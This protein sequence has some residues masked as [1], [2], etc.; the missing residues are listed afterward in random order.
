[1][2]NTELTRLFQAFEQIFPGA[3]LK[4]IDNN[5]KILLET[6]FPPDCPQET[7]IYS[8]YKEL[9]TLKGKEGRLF[10][11]MS[12]PIYPIY[13][14][15][16]FTPPG[17]IN[18]ILTAAK[19]ADSV[20][21]LFLSKPTQMKQETRQSDVSLLLDHLLHPAS[22]EDHTYTALLATELG[23]D[24]SLPR[25]VCIFQ[26]E[27]EG[28]SSASRAQITYSILQTMGNFVSTSSRQDIL[29][30]FGS[31]E[32]I[33]CH[34]MEGDFDSG[35]FLETLYT[36]IN[37]NY[38]VKCSVGVG[39][40]VRSL[41]DYGASLSSARSSF[42]YAGGRGSSGQRIYYVTDFLVEHLVYQI[43]ET[44]FEHFF[45]KELSYLQCNETAFETL[46]AL[47]E[48]D[49]DILPASEALFIHRNT[50]IFRLN[51]LKKHLG[52]NPLHCD[53]DRF[54]LIL[55]YHY[56]VKKYY[57]SNHITEVL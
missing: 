43:P 21:H 7:A 5:G 3:G 29:G 22:T 37:K 26:M 20:I 33:L 4:I 54:K 30:S 34:V 6:P 56:Y 8:N 53:N 45:R 48:H 12:F 27:Y 19:M 25:S 41:E 14:L 23:F 55:L 18:D 42:L 16:I 10:F 46:K 40:T 32:I 38:P 36:Y 11:K 50:M 24:M 31:N 57:N 9:I 39:I 51:Q 17:E 35:Q 52:L 28:K 44:V 15:F 13:Q 1:M 47:V 2:Q 49:M